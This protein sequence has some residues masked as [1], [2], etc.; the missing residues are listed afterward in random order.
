MLRIA[1]ADA[2]PEAVLGHELRALACVSLVESFWGTMQL[3]LLDS[4][5]WSTR[6]ELA[7][8]IFEW[9][10]CWYNA[11][12]RHSNIGMLSPVDYEAAHALPDHDH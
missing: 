5:I 9:I 6:A 2:Q 12:R 4:R 7:T 8:A 1:C 10:E 11:L 3:E